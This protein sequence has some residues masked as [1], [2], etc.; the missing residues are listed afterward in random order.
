MPRP[1]ASVSNV[2]HTA[3]VP[4]PGGTRQ[5]CSRCGAILQEGD[6]VAAWPEGTA[7]IHSATRAGE[8]FAAYEGASA[9]IAPPC[10]PPGPG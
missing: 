7:V 3:A 1:G 9:A 4:D 8:Q 6:P 2:L 10:R 5:R